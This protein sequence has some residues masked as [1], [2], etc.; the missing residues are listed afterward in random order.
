M[1]VPGPAVEVREARTRRDLNAFIKFPLSLYAK[2][3]FM[4][5][6]WCGT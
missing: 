2:D 6:S 4:Y 1:S 3:P 5:P